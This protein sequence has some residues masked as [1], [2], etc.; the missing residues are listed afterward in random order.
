MLLAN[1]MLMEQPPHASLLSDDHPTPA[2]AATPWVLVDPKE[3]ERKRKLSPPPPPA[4]AAATTP[5][6]TAVSPS[7]SP[8]PPP[9]A[10]PAQ[11]IPTRPIPDILSD[12]LVQLN[13][14]MWD[15]IRRSDLSPHDK[16]VQ[17]QQLLQRY[18]SLGE[19]YELRGPRRQRRPP[20]PSIEAAPPPPEAAAAAEEEQQQ[21][22][23]TAASS[24]STWE[25]RV[26]DVMPSTFRNKAKNLL[27]HIRGVKDLSWTPSGE[28][29]YQGV[30]VPQSHI[31]DLVRDMMSERTTVEDPVG[32]ET[33]ALALKRSN[34]PKGFIGH[35]G[36]KRWMQ[37]Q[38]QQPEEEEEEEQTAAASPSTPT[39]IVAGRAK[40]RRLRRVVEED[41]DDDD[42][43]IEREEE[44]GATRKSPSL[45]QW[46]RTK[47]PPWLQYKS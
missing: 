35:K 6:S 34:V 28:M 47:T 15:V 33:F 24:S 17:Y 44:E 27:K 14:D 22:Q 4:A 23:G 19:Q 38:Q 2:A 42:V 39:G 36:R 32:W 12:S 9:P 25:D 37:Q 10:P 21:Q 1:P 29:V 7:S 31:I 26:V 16:Y 3:M 43:D 8:P 30:T 5:P 13:E 11:M 41:D 40:R 45:L 18:L 20:P 46:F